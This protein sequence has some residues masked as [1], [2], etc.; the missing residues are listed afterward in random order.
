MQMWLVVPVLAWLSVIS[1]FDLRKREIPHSAWVIIPLAAAMVYRLFA[2]EWQLVILA[3]LVA[4]VSERRRLADWTR[5]PLDG[6]SIWIPPLVL[7]VYWGMLANPIGALAIVGFWLAWE[8]HA[9]GG[10][11]AVAS[12]S[13]ALIWP[14]L[15]F[16]LSLLGVHL[17]AAVGAT[18]YGLLREHR[19][20]LHA[21]PGLPLLLA[22]VITFLIVHGV[23]G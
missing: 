17:A 8:L 15:P 20:R 14:E 5:L 12:I 11:D 16:V 19:W 6:W 21:L 7:L 3:A 18:A 4:L 22:T 23:A 2:G 13:L 1:I 10:A 9:W